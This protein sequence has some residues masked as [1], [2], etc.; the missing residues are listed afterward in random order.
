MEGDPLFMSETVAQHSL[1]GPT[2]RRVKLLQKQV[3]VMARQ[4]SASWVQNTEMLG[5]SHN[6][7]LGYMTAEIGFLGKLYSWSFEEDLG[8]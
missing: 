6:T 8:S 2:Q 7:L 5:P 4:S 3:L 1:H